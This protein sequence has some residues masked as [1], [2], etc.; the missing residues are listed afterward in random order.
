MYKILS[1]GQNLKVLAKGSYQLK[2]EVRVDYQHC[3]KDPTLSCATKFRVKWLER[4]VG[5]KT[6]I[7]KAVMK[8]RV[9]AMSEG[10]CVFSQNREGNNRA[11]NFT[12]SLLASTIH[13]SSWQP[14]CNPPPGLVAVAGG[15]CVLCSNDW[16]CTVDL[17]ILILLMNC[18]NIS[19]LTYNNI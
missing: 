12:I 4:M 8:R 5:A 14:A 3:P 17:K 18:V 6:K 16:G 1:R 15:T 13:Q 10:I 19:V 7:Q 2:V 11:M 9:S